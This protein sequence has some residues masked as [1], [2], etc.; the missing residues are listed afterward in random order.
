MLTVRDATGHDVESVAAIVN[1]AFEVERPVRGPR[2]NRTS[3]ENVREL[4]ARADTTFFV[5]EQEGRV[6]GSVM[7]RITGDTGYFGMLAVDPGLQKGGIGRTLRERAEAFCK[8]R[9]CA[10]MTL[11]TGDFRTEL[12]PYYQRA[13]YRVVRIEPGPSEWGLSKSFQVVH[14]AKSL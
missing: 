4:M 9:G 1:A 3:A 10:E 5:A 13:G 8:E 14:M 11:T 2:G 6:V 12:L 7:V